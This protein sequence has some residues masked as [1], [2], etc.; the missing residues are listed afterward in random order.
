MRK[1]LDV[2]FGLVAWAIGIFTVATEFF[3]YWKYE[4]AW[5]DW[6]APILWSLC[7]VLML[8]LKNRRPLN[9]WWVW[10]SFPLAFLN[11]LIFAVIFIAWSR[12]GG[13]P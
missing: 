7:V 9:L 2:C 13:A 3:F 1:N 11:W 4:F 6:F 10:L 8:V 5:R 12:G